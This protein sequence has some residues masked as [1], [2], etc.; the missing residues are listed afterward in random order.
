[1]KTAVKP[2]LKTKPLSNNKSFISLVE[3]ETN[4]VDYK[5]YQKLLIVLISMSTILILPELPGELENI[6]KS[7]NSRQQCNVW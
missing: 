1:M 5:F 7:Y 3:K 4:L 6:C 2:D